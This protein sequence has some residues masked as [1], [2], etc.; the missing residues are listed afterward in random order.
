MFPIFS[1]VFSLVG[2]ARWWSQ[3][4]LYSGGKIGMFLF[5][6]KNPWCGPRRGDLYQDFLQSQCSF[7]VFVK[8]VFFENHRGI[9]FSL[10]GGQSGVGIE[11]SICSLRFSAPK[12]SIV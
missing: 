10:K 5:S 12:L 2:N 8:V 9:L 6:G 3:E 7:K 1:R 4:T 11:R